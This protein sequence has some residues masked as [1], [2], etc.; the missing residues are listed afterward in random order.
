MKNILTKKAMSPLIIMASLF[1]SFNG[2]AVT[3]LGQEE[4][5]FSKIWSSPS[6]SLQSKVPGIKMQKERSFTEREKEK[7]SPL[8]KRLPAAQ[9]LDLL[10]DK[11]FKGSRLH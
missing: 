8:E 11:D 1:F 3:T 6:Q 9:T 10:H 2:N 7:V 5:V 4:D